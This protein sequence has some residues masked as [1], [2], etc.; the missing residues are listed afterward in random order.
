[1][2]LLRID[3]KCLCAQHVTQGMLL[4]SLILASLA[5]KAASDSCYGA[6]NLLGNCLGPAFCHHSIVLDARTL[7]I[8]QLLF[9]LKM[10]L[11]AN[12]CILTAVVLS[13]KG[14]LDVRAILLGKRASVA[15][16]ESCYDTS[17]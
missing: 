10:Q 13:G 3:S 6:S 12:H 8:E 9:I 7:D 11:R 2:V 4:Q 16:K 15:V 1:M 14:Q 17:P 5:A